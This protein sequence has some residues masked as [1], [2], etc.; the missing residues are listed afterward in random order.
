MDVGGVIVDRIAAGEDTSFFG[1]QPLLTP[2]VDGVFEA[3]A[4]L[5]AD[6][7]EGRVH[8]VSKAGPKVAGRT[9]AWLHHHEFFLRTGVP[10]EN[11]HFVRERA[12]KGPVCKRLAVT[13]FVDDRLDVL[14]HLDTVT[15]RHLFIGGL[16]D[17]R[18]PAEVPPWAAVAQTWSE[19]VDRIRLSTRSSGAPGQPG[20]TR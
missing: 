5:V 4:R 13:H 7:F 12:D 15:H 17:E 10:A 11:V 14:G 6:P 19:L 3:L 1:S 9:R 2:A 8:L 18:P 20:P 16:G